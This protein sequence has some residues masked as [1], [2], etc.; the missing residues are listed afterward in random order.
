MSF[1]NFADESFQVQL[2]C[3][4]LELLLNLL[5]FLV[6]SYDF[7]LVKSQ[8]KACFVLKFQD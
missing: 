3:E 6:V 2:V 5:Y 7:L 8:R 4:L 1:T